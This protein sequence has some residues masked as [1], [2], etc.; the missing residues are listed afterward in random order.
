LRLNGA[1]VVQTSGTLP[2]LIEETGLGVS[3][4]TPSY[5][6]NDKIY[7]MRTNFSTAFTTLTFMGGSGDWFNALNLND[8]WDYTWID[9][10]TL[11][12]SWQIAVSD[13]SLVIDSQKSIS[14]TLPPFRMLLYRGVD[15][16]LHISY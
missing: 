10:I 5:F 2:G 4:I 3:N 12:N 13:P 11:N 16:N 1:N 7:F 14:A 6:S 9:V 15:S 8:P